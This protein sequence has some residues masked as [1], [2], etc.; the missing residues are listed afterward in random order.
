MEMIKGNITK[1]EKKQ[2]HLLFYMDQNSDVNERSD[3]NNK[4]RRKTATA[5]N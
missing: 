2:P 1:M 3:E 4:D 5:G